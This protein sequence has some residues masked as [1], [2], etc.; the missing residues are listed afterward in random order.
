MGEVYEQLERITHD[1]GEIISYG[2]NA[3][4]QIRRVT[5]HRES[6]DG[7]GE[8][9]YVKDIGYDEFGQRVVME[10]GNGVKTSYT[11][12]PERRWLERIVTVDGTGTRLQNI[13]YDINPV[14]NVRERRGRVL[15]ETNLRLRQFIPADKSGRGE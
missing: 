3:G 9:E 1:D 15:H 2:Y 14:G 6:T 12:D 4:G 10:Y 11:Y 8:F 13:T 5:G 7:T